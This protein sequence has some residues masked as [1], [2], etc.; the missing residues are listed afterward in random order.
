MIHEGSIG[1]D[2]EGSG[3]G[4]EIFSLHLPEET[5]ESREVLLEIIVGVQPTNRATHEYKSSTLSVS[6]PVP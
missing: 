5:E 2:L 3:N 4:I 6:Q 1:K